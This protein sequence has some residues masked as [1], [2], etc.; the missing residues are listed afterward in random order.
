NLILNADL[1]AASEL[2]P[3]IK[4]NSFKIVRR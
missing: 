4:L 3:Y 2:A 1:N